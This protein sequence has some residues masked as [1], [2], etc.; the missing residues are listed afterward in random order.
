MRILRMG[1]EIVT[2]MLILLVALMNLAIYSGVVTGEDA[3]DAFERQAESPAA[4][5]LKAEQND[6]DDLP[7]R[8]VPTQGRQH[9]VSGTTVEFCP[10]GQR[11][12][13]CYASNPPSSGLHL[14][15]EQGVVLADGSVI[16]IPPQP[17]V[18]AAAIPRESIPHILEHAGVYV[19][20]NCAEAACEE[21]VERLI[22]V[23]SQQ[24]DQ[25]KRVVLAPSPDLAVDTIGMS[26]WTRADAFMTVEYEDDRVRE[27]IE[28]HSCRFDPEG[29]CE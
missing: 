13:G 7:G 19:G 1:P 5:A 25:G 14:G 9:V 2:W 8:F 28:T 17:G 18:Y 21:T 26:A 29:F 4:Q 12:D 23:V 20:Y 11:A 27:F 16:D 10:D 6:G 24:L 3:I 15:V 22:I